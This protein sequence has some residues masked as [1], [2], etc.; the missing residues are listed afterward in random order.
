LKSGLSKTKHPLS[1][2]KATERAIAPLSCT[3]RELCQQNSDKVRTYAEPLQ[4]E[5]AMPTLLLLI[6]GALFSI[7]L[8]NPAANVARA[9]AAFFLVCC[10]LGK[11]TLRAYCLV[12]ELIK[13]VEAV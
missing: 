6:E 10:C 3:F 2:K 12:A 11:I 8:I 13:I 4:V 9:Q 5:W 1:K 7:H